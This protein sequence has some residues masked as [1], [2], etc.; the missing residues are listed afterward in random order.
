MTNEEMKQ[1]LTQGGIATADIEKISDKFD[2]E[3]ITELV[4]AANTPEE[5]FAVIHELY[6]ELEVEALQ[7]QC[8]FVKEQVEAALN[9]QKQSEPME[10]TEDE[11]DNVAGGGFFDS[12]GGWF[13]KNWKAVAVGAAIV[14]G[15]ALVCTGVGA[16]VGAAITYFTSHA[17]LSAMGASLSYSTFALVAGYTCTPILTGTGAAIGAAVGTAVGGTVTGALAGTGNLPN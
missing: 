5:A 10:L 11:L 8:D 2:A 3:K 7:K 4:E 13:K 6:P 1:A 15:A 14:V 9:E 12:V 16:G 17:A